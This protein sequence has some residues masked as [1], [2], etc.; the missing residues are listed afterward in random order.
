MSTHRSYFN[1]NNTI[2]YNSFVNTGKAPYTELY[3][4]SAQDVISSPGFSRF[5][6]DLDLSELISKIQNSC[7]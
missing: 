4:G 5:I 6:F 2:Q 1:R 7:M 3:F